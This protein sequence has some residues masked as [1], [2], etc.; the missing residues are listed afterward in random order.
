MVSVHVLKASD[1]LSVITSHVKMVAT[2]VLKACI[3]FI[4]ITSEEATRVSIQGSVE[5]KFR[6]QTSL[7]FFASCHSY[8]F[9]HQTSL[10]L[11]DSF[12]P[13]PKQF[14]LVDS[15]SI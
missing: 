15:L 10:Y 9:R 11:S 12:I 13:L 5:D 1:V 8:K 3:S 4:Y 6:H 2:A 14:S 7:Y